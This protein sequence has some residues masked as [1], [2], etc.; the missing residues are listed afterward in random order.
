MGD[1]R[2]ERVNSK[3]IAA[4]ILFLM[5]CFA[6]A[7][8]S[9]GQSTV[10]LTAD[11]EGQTGPDGR[12]FARLASLLGKIREERPSLLVDA[13]NSIIGAEA[14]GSRGKV[15]IEAYSSLGYDAVN[16]SYRD[17]WYGKEHTLALIK[18]PKTPFVSANLVDAD[19]GD[20]LLKPYVVKELGDE[21]VAILGITH[22]PIGVDHLPHLKKQLAGIRIEEPIEALGRWL[23]KVRKESDKVILLYY[24]LAREAVSIQKRYSDAVDLILVG[25]TRPEYLPKD[26]KP[27]I[28]ATR[29][30]GQGIA[31]IRIAIRDGTTT[32]EASQLQ[33][34]SDLKPDEDMLKLLSPYLEP[35]VTRE[36]ESAVGL[37]RHAQPLLPDVIEIE[38]TYPL[39]SIAQNRAVR[40]TANDV[41]IRGEYGGKT[42]P[43]GEKFL[44]LNTEWENII[45]TS[46]IIERETPTK[47]LVRN[48]GDHLYLV[49]NGCRVSRLD[50][51][52][53]DYPGHLPVS[54][55]SLER[56]G[57]KLRGNLLFEIPHKDIETLELRF[58][59]YAHG[60]IRIPLKGQPPDIETVEREP[61]L[62]LRS[63]EFL[64]MGVFGVERT[65]KFGGE[66]APRGM[67][68]IGVD[69]R[70]RSLFTFE[71]DA[72]AFDPKA[73]EG[74]TI[75]VGTVADWGEARK[76]L[77]LVVDGEYAYPPAEQTVLPEEPR[78]LP[79]VMTGDLVVFAAP[80]KLNSLELRCD[81]PNAQAPGEDE[82]IHPESLTFLLE[83]TPPQIRKRKVIASVEDDTIDVMVVRQ[84]VMDKFAG[85][86]AEE[87][88]KFLG[89]EITVKST[90]DK[91]EFFQTES[92]LYYVCKDGEQLEIDDVTYKGTRR[93]TEIVWIP[94][95]ERR[96]FRII[97]RIPKSESKPRLAYRGYSLA[98][99]LDL[100]PLEE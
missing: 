43:E 74:D 85:E 99:I 79:D 4:T 8:P 41:G 52:A 57:S 14:I 54:A 61:L 13:G 23:P 77:H 94:K 5:V 18:G 60:H 29:A 34:T 17:V 30:H 22:E 2:T 32:V 19:T 96:T 82:I 7:T 58:Y 33:V 47:Y 51:H 38:S 27:P 92:Q 80:Q 50:L 45:P 95:G 86:Q 1:Y 64:E 44:V 12:D 70:G 89:L 3:G 53:D 71:A 91:G 83:G 75:D 78:F 97:Y 26:G 36:I 49:V 9:T 100:E 25:G 31:R 98:E 73:E 76:Y 59:D 84:N 11:L 39:Y 68:F 28:V 21:S 81:F 48:L 20:Q 72:T 90:G 62:P 93:P 67:V 88:Q 55:F 24:G 40:V 15:I 46:L 69:L 56:I 16:L 65:R 35:G 10:L 87:D 42:A 66:E 63:N 6:C 37:E